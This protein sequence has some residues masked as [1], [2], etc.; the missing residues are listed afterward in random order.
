MR[1]H[2][3]GMAAFRTAA[4]EPPSDRDIAH[5]RDRLQYKAAQYGDAPRRYAASAI[6]M[7]DTINA[8]DAVMRA[9]LLWRTANNAYSGDRMR[10]FASVSDF[11]TAGPTM[12]RW[13]MACKEVR[14]AYR[15]QRIEGY[16]DSYVDASPG[17]V[18]DLHVD[19]RMVT[20]GLIYR[21]GD[22]MCFD[23]H[24]GL[25]EDECLEPDQVHDIVDTWAMAA[26]FLAQNDDD[27]TS[28]YG[29]KM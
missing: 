22:D 11:Q 1:I 8:A 16:R 28:L 24:Y 27:I 25:P 26:H 23:I 12:Q 2:T 3:G 6:E 18:G 21:D 17:L 7:Y 19:Y 5:L 20:D 15:K 29:C 10:S 14:E 4:Y 9:R 13:V